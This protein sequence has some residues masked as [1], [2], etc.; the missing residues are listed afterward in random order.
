MITNKKIKMIIIII[1]I[2]I[3]VRIIIMNMIRI[4]ALIIIITT[5]QLDPA[6]EK[7]P[8]SLLPRG[9]P[10]IAVALQTA[11][12]NLCISVV[13]FLFRADATGTELQSE[14]GFGTTCAAARVPPRARPELQL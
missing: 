10:G 12:A 6:P 11:N 3:I 2:F 8:R 13:T 5:Q 14:S 9:Y 7:S 1:V 4:I